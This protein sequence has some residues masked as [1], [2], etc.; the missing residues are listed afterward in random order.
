MNDPHTQQ[1][2]RIG[3][4]GGS[5]NPIHLGHLAIAQQACN[6]WDLDRVL[7]MPCHIQPHKHPTALASAHHRHAMLELAL[8][9]TPH[10]E[11]CDIE[12]ARGGTSFA[13]DS[14]HTLQRTYPQDDICF[15]IGGDTL[16]ELYKWHRIDDLLACC[17]ILTLARPG[18]N[19]RSMSAHSLNLPDS[20]AEKL[21]SHVETATHIDISASQVRSSVA[22]GHTISYLVPRSVEAYIQKQSLFQ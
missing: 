22:Q 18:A 8:A 21:L 14:V 20:V 6:T 17:T 5:F 3:V 11:L 13:I 4:L 2:R 19:P 7:F 12:L 1:G 10:F 16:P 15:I 9:E